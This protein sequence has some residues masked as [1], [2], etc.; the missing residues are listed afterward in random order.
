[1]AAFGW[2]AGFA[3]AALG[4]LALAEQ[5]KEGDGKKRLGPQVR[6]PN[7]GE[8]IE[9]AKKE[10]EFIRKNRKDGKVKALVV[11]ALGRCGRGAI[12]FFQK[13]GVNE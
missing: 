5:S 12:D 8:L 4:L 3:G 13:A 1:M 10:I 11:G 7:E 9:H 2:H 6:Y